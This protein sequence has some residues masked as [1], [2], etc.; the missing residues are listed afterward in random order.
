MFNFNKNQ[1]LETIKQELLDEMKAST[2]DSPEYKNALK[3]YRKICA[4]ENEKSSKW[5]SS[6]A[7][8]AVAGN[9]SVVL[10][11]VAYET[12][13]VWKSKAMTFLHPRK[14]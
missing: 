1:D 13:H 6:D 9:L 5:P 8:L 12:N 7:W 11:I 4:M 14:L 10:I 2:S 3:Q